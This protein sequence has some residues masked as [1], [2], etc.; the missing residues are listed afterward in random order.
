MRSG[1]ILRSDSQI[2][3]PITW[4]ANNVINI[5][6]VPIKRHQ[7]MHHSLEKSKYCIKN[8]TFDG[9]VHTTEYLENPLLNSTPKVTFLKK[10]STANGVTT[11]KLYDVSDD[12][13]QLLE[14]VRVWHVTEADV[15]ITYQEW[16]VYS[17]DVMSTLFTKIQ[18]GIETVISLFIVKKDTYEI[19]IDD[20][21]E[22]TVNVKWFVVSEIAAKHSSRYY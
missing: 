17:F 12:L 1:P 16:I 20:N 6:S 21:N 10:M 22:A 2:V 15:T 7:P 19:K 14:I 3:W 9:V 5:I 18:N 13:Y 8:T 11:T 4:P